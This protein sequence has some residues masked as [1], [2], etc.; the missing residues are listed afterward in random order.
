MLSMDVSGIPPDNFINAV[1]AAKRS[2]D[3]IMNHIYEAVVVHTGDEPLQAALNAIDNG[4]NR[5]E[6]EL[7]V[8]AVWLTHLKDCVIPEMVSVLE[9][10]P[11]KGA[12]WQSP[13]KSKHPTP[14]RTIGFAPQ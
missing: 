14:T 3:A 2:L 4:C 9:K 11:N 5:E 6:G 1:M 7:A 13:I 10:M 12:V 8:S